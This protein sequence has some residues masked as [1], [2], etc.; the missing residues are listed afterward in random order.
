MNPSQKDASVTVLAESP[1][2]RGGS[3]NQDNIIVYEPDYRDS[4]WQVSASGGTPARLT[5]FEESKHTTHRWPQFMPDGKHFLFFATNHSGDSSQGIYF[6]SL[7][8][9]SYKHILDA[10]SGGQYAS[11]YLLYHEQSQLLAQKFDPASGAVRPSLRRRLG[12]VGRRRS[13][14]WHEE[15]AGLAV[16]R[17]IPSAHTSARQYS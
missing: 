17:P 2:P 6:G 11:G 4:L 15:A 14:L 1:N 10:D 12:G 13:H 7:A 8:D 3:W 9:G 16:P 5:K